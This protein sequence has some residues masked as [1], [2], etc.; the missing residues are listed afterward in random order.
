MKARML[1]LTLLLLAGCTRSF[2]RR[3]AD[4]ETYPTIAEHEVFPAYDIGRTQ[5]KPGP[6]SRLADPFDPDHPP[7]PPDD[8]A[9]ALFMARP[10]GMKGAKGWEK[11]GVTNLIEPPGWEQALGLDES[12]ILKLDQVKAVEI[13][14]LNS[15]EYQTAL[16]AVYLIA[17]SLTLNRYEFALHWF[18][19]TATTF[20]HFGSDGTETNTLD[21]ESHLGFTRNFAA[22]GQLLVDFANSMVFEFTGHTSTVQPGLT[23]TL[24]QPLLRHFG[25]KVRLESLTQGE[26]NLLYAVRDFARFRKQFW[27]GIAIGGSTGGA[28]I[29][30]GGEAAA[31]G[32]GAPTPSTGVTGAGAAT[33]VAPTML[34]GS[35]ISA[36]AAGAGLAP[37]GTSAAAATPGAVV[38]TGAGTPAGVVVSSGAATGA[39]VGGGALSAAGAQGGGYLDLL[40]AMQ[41]LR[42]S[43]DSLRRQEKAYRYYEALYPVRATVV[44]RD[45]FYQSFVAARQAVVDAQAALQ[46][47]LDSFKLRLG[48]PPRLPVELDDALLRQFELA[49]PSVERLRDEVEAFQRDRLKEIGNPPTAETLRRDYAT[50]HKYADQ[51]R[52]AARLAEADVDRWGRRLESPP[53]AEQDAEQR[54][55]TRAAFEKLTQQL[56]E[57]T[58][59]LAKRLAEIEQHAAA[60]TERNRE[61]AWTNLTERDVKS[62]LAVLDTVIAVQTEARIY[63]IELPYAGMPESDALAFAKENRLDFQ[64][65]LGIVTDAWRQVWVAAKALR[66]DLNFLAS[67][68]VTVAKASQYV[69]GIEFDGPLDRLAERNAYRASLITYQRAKRSYVELSDQI[70]SQVR[71]DLRQ[72]DR[73]RVDFDSAREQVLAAAR[74]VES[75]RLNLAG[76]AAQQSPTATLDLLQ[77]L[78]ALLSAQN[79]LAANY[80]SFEQQRV[81]L[82]LDL[83][84]LQLDQR[85]FPTDVSIPPADHANCFPANFPRSEPRVPNRDDPDAPELPTPRRVSEPSD[86]SQAGGTSPSGSQ[87]TAQG[88]SAPGGHAL[89]EGQPE[90]HVIEPPSAPEP[91]PAHRTRGATG[92]PPGS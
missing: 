19:T 52:A 14:L 70:E 77:G 51:I 73:L 85:G 26:R 66:G 39:A 65:R 81:Q 32:A 86:L 71:Q 2:Y 42:N 8:M 63:L 58:A 78:S 30:I 88:N 40:L 47:A 55:R 62:V 13:A 7:K 64:N 56:P 83:E 15:R 16:E 11:F 76:P 59:D 21:S 24:L 89:V 12:G 79:A 45:Q 9:A 68:V 84:A 35:S 1:L 49:D 61:V 17:L 50:L 20:T 23:V 22:G 69:M 75:V 60:V 25:R 80:I 37:G 43:Q 28:G 90:V 53:R 6:G 36:P 57:V 44:Q 74:Q 87:S 3:S 27:A 34:L 72:L 5:L 38:A 4:R 31:L 91:G 41:T 29:V 48:L 33:L 67:A 54:D 18:G 10:G 46:S 92:G 82:L